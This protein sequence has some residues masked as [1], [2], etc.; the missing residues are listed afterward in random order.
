MTTTR[1]EFSS[2][3]AGFFEM[4]TED[5]RR[6]LPARFTP[7]E[8]NYGRSILV[9]NLYDFTESPVGPYQEVV[10]GVMVPPRIVDGI[11]PAG[12]AFPWQ[13]ATSTAASR[14]HAIERWHLPHWPEDVQIDLHEEGERVQGSVRVHG[15]VAMRLQI[16]ARQ[17]KIEPQIYQ[18]FMSEG[19]EHFM[20]RILY[21]GLKSEHEAGTGHLELTP[22]HPFNSGL[23]GIDF[24]DP[25]FRE[26][27]QRGTQTFEPL[28]RIT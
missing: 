6:L 10:Y 20:A 7:L 8:V 22:G 17:W 18:S 15:E 23:E 14:E 27:W 9:V 21:E 26:I 28:Q 13:V 12:A 25:A 2:A 3:I 1:Y 4:P 11:L 19:A 16:T 24:D 5:A